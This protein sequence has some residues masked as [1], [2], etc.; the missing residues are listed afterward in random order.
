MVVDIYRVSKQQGKYPLSPTMRWII[1]A[2]RQRSYSWRHLRSFV[3]SLVRSIGSWISLSAMPFE[4]RGSQW[5]V[6]LS[7]MKFTCSISRFDVFRVSQEG[8][9]CI[10]FVLFDRFF[11]ISFDEFYSKKHSSRLT[12]HYMLRWNKR[13]CSF[14]LL[15]AFI[16]SKYM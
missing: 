3:G 6:R 16:G 4:I 9:F 7:S 11:S 1:A 5:A 14:L 8:E 10:F 12:L 15:Q 13:I 2:D